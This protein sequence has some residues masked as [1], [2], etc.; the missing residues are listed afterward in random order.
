M[1]PGEEG[2]G[3]TVKPTAVPPGEPDDPGEQGPTATQTP[4]PILPGD[5]DE[6]PEE[7]PGG[8]PPGEPDEPVEQGPHSLALTFP[9]EIVIVGIFVVNVWRKKKTFQYIT[10]G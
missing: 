1:D 9:L 8:N 10:R 2:P 5:P 7:G 4:I 6:P 3:A